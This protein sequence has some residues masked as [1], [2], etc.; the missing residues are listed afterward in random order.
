MKARVAVVT[1][2]PVALCLLV[3]LSVQAQTEPEGERIARLEEAVTSLATKTDIS[4]LR[5]ELREDISG[6][7]GEFR[8]LQWIVGVLAVLGS[9]IGANLLPLIKEWV[10]RS[11]QQNRAR[12]P[13]QQPNH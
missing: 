7:R 13:T 6:L 3:S 8:S 5:G 12:A 2:L 9:A 10:Q 1:I 11:A 4:D